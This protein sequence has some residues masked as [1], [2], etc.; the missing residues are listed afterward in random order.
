MTVRPSGRSRVVSILAATSS[1]SY[2][3]GRRRNRYGARAHRGGATGT[4]RGDPQANCCGDRAL[5]GRVPR[6]HSSQRASIPRATYHRNVRRGGRRERLDHRLRRVPTANPGNHGARIPLRRAG[7]DKHPLLGDR[8]AQRA[9]LP[10]AGRT[11][12]TRWRGAFLC[13]QGAVEFSQQFVEPRPIRPRENCEPLGDARLVGGDDVLEQ[14][15]SLIGKEE[16][17]GPTLLNA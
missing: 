16:P 5:A 13:F 17:V 10:A 1:G 2:Q 7:V 9:A 14:P 11:C 6:A 4:P 8:V 15:P 12:R 3:R